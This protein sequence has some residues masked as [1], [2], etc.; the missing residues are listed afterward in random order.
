MSEGRRNM[1]LFEYHIRT[2][3]DSDNPINVFLFLRIFVDTCTRL[4]STEIEA[5][6][7]LQFLLTEGSLLQF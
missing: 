7:M 4:D 1:V 2:T 6:L 3:F 5:R